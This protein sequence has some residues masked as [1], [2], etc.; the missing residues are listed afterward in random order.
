MIPDTITRCDHDVLTY[1]GIHEPERL[2]RL[3][4]GQAFPHEILDELLCDTDTCTA[5][6][7]ED[8]SLVFSMQLR[9]FDGID[10]AA[11]DDSARALHVVVEAREG[12]LVP[13]QCWKRVLEIF[14]LDY[15]AVTYQ[16]GKTSGWSSNYATDPGHFSFSAAMSSSINSRSSS[17]V[18][19]SLLLPI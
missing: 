1:L 8:R 9:G 7:K 15:N 18:I 2:L 12:V 13:L 5:R 14:E 16:P 11:Q 17:A 4:F 10:E 19:L 3:V 6:S